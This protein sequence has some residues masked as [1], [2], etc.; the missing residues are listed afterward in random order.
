MEDTILHVWPVTIP[1]LHC[2][3]VCALKPA[4]VPP[5]SLDIAVSSLT[6]PRHTCIPNL[7]KTKVSPLRSP[8]HT[9]VVV[10]ILILSINS[11]IR[12]KGHS[13]TFAHVLIFKMS[14]F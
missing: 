4:L 13:T 12:E 8:S 14:C 3:V 6:Y 10:I 9:V 11:T 5:Y 7:R 2:Y 1:V